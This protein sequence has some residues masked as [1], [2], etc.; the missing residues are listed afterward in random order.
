MKRTFLRLVVA[1]DRL[2]PATGAA[3]NKAHGQATVIPGLPVSLLLFEGDLDMEPLSE[4][5]ALLAAARHLD[6][7]R[8]FETIGMKCA[9]RVTLACGTRFVY[10]IS[11]SDWWLSLLFLDPCQATSICPSQGTR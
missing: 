10:V 7:R 11:A 8:W 9:Y 3:I 5:D 4:A 1:A 2:T 6:T